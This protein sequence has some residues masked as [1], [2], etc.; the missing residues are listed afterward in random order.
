[1]EGWH[2][3]L[4]SGFTLT[5]AGIGSVSFAPSASGSILANVA[6]VSFTYSTSEPAFLPGGT[7]SASSEDSPSVFALSTGVTERVCL[8]SSSSSSSSMFKTMYSDE[9]VPLLGF[10]D[11][12]LLEEDEV[13]QFTGRPTRRR[14][15][16]FLE[17]TT[18][19]YFWES[20]AF[21]RFHQCIV[22]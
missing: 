18:L 13:L 19:L 10:F 12:V 2:S 22:N 7:G 15:L 4:S 3:H 9:Q 14:T 1:M 17:Q 16:G 8:G 11:V 5:S 20:D 6:N 21:R